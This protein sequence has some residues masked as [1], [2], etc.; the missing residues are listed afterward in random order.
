MPSACS[1][2]HGGW[3]MDDSRPQYGLPDALTAEK[4]ESTLRRMR[5]VAQDARDHGPT[6]IIH[7]IEAERRME[8]H[9]DYGACWHA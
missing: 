1:T 4:L 6:E 9:G 7:P 8:C 2:T 3:S 5:E